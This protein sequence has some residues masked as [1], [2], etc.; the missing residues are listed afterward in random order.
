[1]TI[2]KLF[3]KASGKLWSN[4]NKLKKYS[5]DCCSE[6][7]DC[8]SNLA[9][10]AWKVVFT[11]IKNRDPPVSP[12]CEKC[13]DYNKSFI[14][15]ANDPDTLDECHWMFV[16]DPAGSFGCY[17][18]Y[19]VQVTVYEIVGEYFIQATLDGLTAVSETLHFRKS[20]GASRPNCN[21]QNDVPLLPFGPSTFF[22]CDTSAATCEI[23]SCP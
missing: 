20:Y 10:P 13:S 18:A 12:F 21:N 14:V 17:G 1:M 3:K 8:A 2:P 19:T 15:P 4:G 5:D 11:G 22:R 9:P 6:C 23:T 7:E 16:H